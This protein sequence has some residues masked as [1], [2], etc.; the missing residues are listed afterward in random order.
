M[1]YDRPETLPEALAILAREPRTVLAG[2]TDLYPAT[3]APALAGAVLDITGLGELA[4][5]VRTRDGLRIG[6]CTTWADDPRRRPSAGLRRA[7]RRR[8]RGRR[9]PDPER[10][11]HRRQPLQRLPGRRRRA[12]APRARRRGRARLGRRRAAAC[13]SARF[14][15]DARRT[16]RRPD[17]ILTAVLI[18]DAALRGRS[19]FLKLGARRY[20]VI[21]I[22]MV[23]V[24]LDRRRRPGRGRRARRRRLRPGRDPPAGGRG[25]APRRPGRRPRSPTASTRRRSPPRCSPIDDVRAERRLPRR[26]GGRAAAPRD[27]R[28]GR[29]R[30]RERCT[31][32]ASASPSTAAAVAFDVAPTRRLSRGAARGGRAHRHQGRLRRRRLR[33]LHRAPRRPPGLR[34]PDPGRPGRRPRG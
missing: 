17:E 5:I 18:P 11:H 7:P 12:A 27:L 8:G 30:R 23:A 33:R 3:T 34:L 31:A 21:S 20:L 15:R 32:R 24:R 29:E 6:A 1:F 16:E 10:R 25:A 22:A 4:G 26:G 9:P 2:G 13:R 14:L 19:A 28:P